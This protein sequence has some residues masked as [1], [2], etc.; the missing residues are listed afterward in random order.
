MRYLYG[1]VLQA[2]L[3][4]TGYICLIYL[5]MSINL[6]FGW[7]SPGLIAFPL[8]L[9]R[10]KELEEE[11]RAKSPGFRGQVD[12]TLVAEQFLEHPRMEQRFFGFRF[13]N[14]YAGGLSMKLETLNKVF[15]T[16][17]TIQG[18]EFRTE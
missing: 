14:L 12:P 10:V 15:T 9:Q 4:F 1:F 8:S 18:L 2:D 3:L 13:D 7:N 6:V 17:A 16:L 5:V 11:A